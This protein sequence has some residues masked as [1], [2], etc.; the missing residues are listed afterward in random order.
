VA[1]LDAAART[2]E[3]GDNEQFSLS[4]TF[5]NSLFLIELF[6]ELD[7]GSAPELE[8][9]IARAEETAAVTI[10]VD[11]S[12]L[13]FI[14]SSGIRALLSATECSRNGNDRLRFL[15]GSGQVKRT[16]ELCGVEERLPIL[17]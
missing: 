6:G 4:L 17:D 9:V 13:Q 10:L 8:G 11:L 3:Q 14:D 15:R 2:T 7:I 12:A 16:L 5:D 1:G